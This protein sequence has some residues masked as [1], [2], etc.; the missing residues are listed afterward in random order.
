MDF[1]VDV[2][3]NPN[4]RQMSKVGGNGNLTTSETLMVGAATTAIILAYHIKQMLPFVIAV[5]GYV[6]IVVRFISQI[7]LETFN[8]A[9]NW[10]I[11]LG[12]YISPV[13][14]TKRSAVDF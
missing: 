7:V 5:P 14:S 6:A 2:N 1:D 11:F 9:A 3:N 12:S 4:E 13:Q 8:I 10:V